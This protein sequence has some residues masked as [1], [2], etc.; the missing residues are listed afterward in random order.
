M[1]RLLVR[2]EREYLAY[3]PVVVMKYRSTI[4]IKTTTL[5]DAFVCLIWL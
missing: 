2:K 4:K 1:S 3:L 5:T